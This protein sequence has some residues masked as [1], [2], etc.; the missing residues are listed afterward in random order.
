MLS[1]R[2]SLGKFGG[3]ERSVRVDRG[4]AESNSSF[5]SAL[6]KLITNVSQCA[7]K[8]HKDENGFSYRFNLNV[9]LNFNKLYKYTFVMVLSLCKNFL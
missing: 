4:V 2:I 3:Y 7:V 9:S 1:V 8:K 6:Q 5:L